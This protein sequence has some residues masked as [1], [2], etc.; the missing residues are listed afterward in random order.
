MQV[1]A[2]QTHGG[3]EQLKLEEWP[4]PVP[5]SGEVVVD[6]RAC[7]LN[8]LDVF[9]LRGMPGLPVHMPRIPGGDITGTVRQV[10]PEVSGHWVG[11]RVLIDPMIEVN[12]RPGTL[13]EHC[14]GG[15]CERIAVSANNLIV[16]PESIPFEVGAALPIAYGTAHRM[17]TTR[18]QLRPQE[19]ILILGA[20]GGV[21]TACVQ[22]AKVIG[23]RIIA[24]ASTAEKIQK[25]QDLG[26]H[27]T[28]NTN[29]NDFSKQAWQLSE[30]RGVDVVVNF[31]GGDTW[32]KSLRA[33]TRHGR[34]LT[35]GATAGFDPQ[36]DIRFI[37]TREL[38]II[39]SDGWTREDLLRLVE[40]VSVGRIN[41]TIDRV[42]PMARVSEAIGLLEKRKVFGKIIL[43]P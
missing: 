23:A 31:T 42:Y 19:L 7:G 37:W 29:E 11:R 4:D 33:L 26:S 41:P 30:K 15:L 5:K 43:T 20:S 17:L 3:L 18:G 2:I 38:Q 6:V 36:T 16:L 9:V 21:G 32:V 8:Y 13:G 24:C 34:L 22:L 40:G 35:C 27:Y 10:G 12:G 25:L 28:I 1:V 14:N 39:G